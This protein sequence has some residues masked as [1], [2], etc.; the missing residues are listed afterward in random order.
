MSKNVH[1]ILLNN[2]VLYYPQISGIKHIL[3]IDTYFLL[4]L[5]GKILDVLIE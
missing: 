5:W 4:V 1:K 3:L 2:N